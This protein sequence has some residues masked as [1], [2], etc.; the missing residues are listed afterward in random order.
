MTILRNRPFPRL[1]KVSNLDTNDVRS[2]KH[3]QINGSTATQGNDFIFQI[4]FLACCLLK[5]W[6][7]LFSESNQNE[8]LSDIPDEFQ[9]NGN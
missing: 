7:L 4:Y 8:T 3:I 2:E 9:T 6:L 5:T 1:A